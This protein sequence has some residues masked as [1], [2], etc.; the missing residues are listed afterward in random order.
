M[1]DARVMCIYDDNYN[2]VIYNVH[3]H[4]HVQGAS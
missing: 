3:V 2:D 4:V 1:N